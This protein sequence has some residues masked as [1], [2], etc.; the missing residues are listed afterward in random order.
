[1]CGLH[2]ADLLSPVLYNCPENSVY[3]GNTWANI[4][5]GKAFLKETMYPH[6][7]SLEEVWSG[8]L[9]VDH[10]KVAGS[11]ALW[12]HTDPF[13][14]SCFF[15]VMAS[16]GLPESKA[17]STQLSDT[18]CCVTEVKVFVYRFLELQGNQMII[19]WGLEAGIRHPFSEFSNCREFP[20]GS[21]G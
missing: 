16:A 19:P 6:G 12:T 10:W 3:R 18:S 5:E 4:A 13:P 9:K 8:V 20:G 11:R 14:V 21:M 1:M 15:L 7:A 2:F 17:G